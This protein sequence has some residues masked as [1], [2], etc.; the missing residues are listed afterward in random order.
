[1]F[2]RLRA[3]ALGRTALLISHRFSSV[4]R[5]DRIVVLGDGRV[6]EAGTHEELVRNGGR[7]AELF[8]LQAA[9]YR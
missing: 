6:Q 3:L 4:R 8:E 5:A 7:Y 2:A 9:A 1:M